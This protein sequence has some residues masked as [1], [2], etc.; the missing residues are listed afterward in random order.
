MQLLRIRRRRKQVCSLKTESLVPSDIKLTE[1]ISKVG[2][3]LLLAVSGLLTIAS[4]GVPRL[5]R[6]LAIVYTLR[7]L[8]L[9]LELIIPS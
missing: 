1:L 8:L 4:I 3:W 9:L 5:L 6:L 2:D 7:L